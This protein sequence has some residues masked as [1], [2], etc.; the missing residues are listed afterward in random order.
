MPY[1]LC[2]GTLP[3]LCRGPTS[4]VLVSYLLCVGVLPVL[5]WCP[6]S[7]VLAPYLLCVGVLPPSYWCPT[8]PRISAQLPK[9]RVCL[10]HEAVREGALAVVQVPH[11]RHIAHQARLVL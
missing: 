3:P 8:A 10:V 6:T 4:F 5:C 2:V 1:L 9:L 7:F 11:E